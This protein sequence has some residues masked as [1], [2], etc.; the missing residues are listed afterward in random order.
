MPRLN[1]P[2]RGYERDVYIIPAQL[3]DI[4]ARYRDPRDMLKNE[5]IIDEIE[6]VRQADMALALAWPVH[7]QDELG[8]VYVMP[9]APWSRRVMG[10]FANALAHAE[11]QRAHAVLKAQRS[12]YVVSVRVPLLQPAGACEL[13]G[14]FGGSGRARAAGI[15][16]MPSADFD[17][18]VAAFTTM[19]WGA[20]VC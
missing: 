13:C 8:S 7:W 5:H 9:D 18:F 20:P 15:D 14:R 3:Y 6:A 1:A 16:A 2:V 17:R 12:G 19:Q 4:L 11:P 10:V